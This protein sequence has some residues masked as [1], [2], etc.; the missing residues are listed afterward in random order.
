MK[1]C[2]CQCSDGNIF[3]DGRVVVVV[4][5]NIC[6]DGRVVVVE[7]NICRDGRVV[8][9]IVEKNICRDGRVVVVVVDKNICRDA[10]RRG[11]AACHRPVRAQSHSSF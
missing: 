4:D 8:V 2:Q 1:I 10:R 5:K 11:V 6:R 7:K 3:K 9:V